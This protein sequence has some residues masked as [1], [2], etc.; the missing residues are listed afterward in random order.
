MK[1]IWLFSYHKLRH[2][3]STSDNGTWSSVVCISKGVED[4]TEVNVTLVIDKSV[5]Y[6]T[7][8][9]SYMEN[10]KVIAVK[11]NCSFNRWG[12][13]HHCVCTVLYILYVCMSICIYVYCCNANYFL[14]ICHVLLIWLQFLKAHTSFI[15]SVYCVKCLMLI[16]H[17]NGYVMYK[18]WPSTPH[19]NSNT[20][21]II[22]PAKPICDFWTS[23]SRI[24]HSFL[25]S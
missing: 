24:I 7:H 2:F 20:L 19:F 8:K 25:L 3:Y 15:H 18:V 14:S 1:Y 16:S 23:H 21:S 6:T 12:P 22:W 13:D 17:N 4:L 9:F 5:I 11:P 10:P